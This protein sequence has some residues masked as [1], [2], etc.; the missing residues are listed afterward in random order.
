MHINYGFIA[1]C[2]KPLCHGVGTAWC[3][4]D[5]NFLFLV[6][7]IPAYKMI[8]VTL[9]GSSRCHF[10]LRFVVFNICVSFLSKVN[11]VKY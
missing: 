11:F 6:A 5:T 7:T 2:S 9:T 8:I 3:A 1:Q 4:L 10:L